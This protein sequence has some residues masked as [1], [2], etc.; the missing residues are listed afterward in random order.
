MQNTFW[1]HAARVTVWTILIVIAIALYLAFVVW[2][3]RKLHEADVRQLEEQRIRNERCRRLALL[4]AIAD[5]IEVA[6]KRDQARLY[7]EAQLLGFCDDDAFMLD[8]VDQPKR[9]A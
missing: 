1:A 2:V 9:S 3:G 6:P 4:S 8:D 5:E 7:R